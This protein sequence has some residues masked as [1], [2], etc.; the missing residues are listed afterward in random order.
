MVASVGVAALVSLLGA[1]LRPAP[2][3]LDVEDVSVHPPTSSTSTSSTSTSTS[4]STSSSSTSTTMRPPT[5]VTAPA[6]VAVAAVPVVAGVPAPWAPT[7]RLVAGQ[8]AVWTSTV[9]VDGVTVF[10]ARL[11]TSLLSIVPYAGTRDPPGTW[12]SQGAIA[13]DVLPH[14]VCAFNGGFQFGTANGGW[15]ADGRVGVPLRTGAASLVVRSD[16]TA[17]VGEWGRDAVLD[18]SVRAVRQNLTLLV[19]G[20]A[21]V[22]AAAQDWRWGATLGRV[23][24]TWR[25]GLGDDG[26]GGLIF[27]GGPGLD[28]AGLAAALVAAHAQ[29]AM[30][31]DINPQWVLLVTYGD[32]PSGNTVAT[33]LSPTMAFGADHFTSADWRD[34][35]VALARAPVSAPTPRPR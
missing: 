6:P 12:S 28:A 34:F 18:A 4:T 15:Y 29:R 17:V 33:K 22:A 25:S 8:P 2:A 16:G 13:A 26:Q 14:A 10:L 31:L 35:V 20:G 3:P 1:A 24:R 7:G 5:P 32:G 30:E 27:A 9:Q 11:D 21:P 19:D 23:T